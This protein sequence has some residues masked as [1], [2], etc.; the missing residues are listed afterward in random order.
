MQKCP[1]F[2]GNVRQLKNPNAHV[3]YKE[4]NRP[5]SVR[6]SQLYPSTRLE[7]SVL[8]FGAAL[9]TRQKGEAY[10]LDLS[11]LPSS[12]HWGGEGDTPAMWHPSRFAF[13]LAPPHTSMNNIYSL[14]GVWR[15]LRVDVW[16]RR[17]QQL[18]INYTS[19][20]P[21]LTS[22]LDIM[23]LSGWLYLFHSSSFMVYSFLI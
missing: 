12:T 1:T 9:F 19:W 18:R 20:W 21:C 4:A 17:Q 16:W 13:S 15:Q 3:S 2:M 6:S 23:A 8:K 10:A 11:T 5:K 22:K 14:L 7:G